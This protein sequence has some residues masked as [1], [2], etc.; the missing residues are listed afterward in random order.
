MRYSKQRNLIL[1]IIRK[2]DTHP[3]AEWIYEEARKEMP[4][5]G[6]ATVYRNLNALVSAGEIERISG[7]GNAD[8]F[9]G[10]V[11][12]HCHMQCV[13]CGKIID[14]Y[15]NSAA[16]MDR[17]RKLTCETFGVEDRNVRISRTILRGVCNNCLSQKN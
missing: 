10:Q 17:L 13:R 14:L 3:S 7:S 12:E 11:A 15:P 8:R 6:I 1:D 9:D 4:S 2:T 5:I 16:N